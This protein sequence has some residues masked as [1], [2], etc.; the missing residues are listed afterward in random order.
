MDYKPR[1][2]RTAAAL[3]VATLLGACAPVDDASNPDIPQ[4][5]DEEARVCRTT[6]ERATRLAL[7][8]ASRGLLY[9]SESDYP[10]DYVSYP[11]APLGR[12]TGAQLL[13][14]LGRPADT[15]VEVRTLD[16]VFSHLVN[17]EVT[18]DDAPRFAALER[19]IR[20]R[21]TY[22]QVFAVGTIQVHLYVVGR[23]RCGALVGLHTISIET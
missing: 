20:Q 9:T 7:E 14:T 19:T 21:L 17:P 8:A 2:M 22:V 18:G 12:L 13:A 3:L 15:A 4:S 1:S 10:F 6:P 16:R 11:T 5:T 23:D